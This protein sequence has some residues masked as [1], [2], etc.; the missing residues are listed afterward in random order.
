M[1][2]DSDKENQPATQQQQRN[3]ITQPSKPNTLDG[4]R[5]R[6]ATADDEQQ[7]QHNIS[8]TKK[9]KPSHNSTNADNT[10]TIPS[11]LSPAP[12]PSYASFD[13][14]LSEKDAAYTQLLDKYNEL[15]KQKLDSMSSLIAQYE[16][17]TTQLRSSSQQLTKHW[18]DKYD[19]LTK[20]QH[21]ETALRKKEAEAAMAVKDLALAEKDK[22]LKE[23]ET[24]TTELHTSLAAANEQISNYLLLTGTS[25]T[26]PA[27]TSS[28]SSS[29]SS[30]STQRIACCMVN[31]SNRQ[32]RIDFVL[33]TSA[34]VEEGRVEY[35][36]KRIEL[37]G[38]AYPKCL[39]GSM[40]FAVDRTPN[41]MRYLLDVMYKKVEDD[42]EEVQEEKAE[43]TEQAA[44][45]EHTPQQQ[46]ESHLEE[47]EQAESKQATEMG[48]GAGNRRG[49]NGVRQRR[50]GGRRSRLTVFRKVNVCLYYIL[51]S[52]LNAVTRESRTEDSV[53]VAGEEDDID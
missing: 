10:S 16:L 53:G 36:P 7:Q 21:K 41:F 46:L 44:S 30:S 39:K 49:D 31:A 9:S 5:N 2:D 32:R 37:G 14:L 45:S 24:S 4:K 18:Q 17:Q 26:A 35:R 11:P 6:A 52:L 8:N 29:S 33:D 34:S 47:S 19:Q 1:H 38:V 3:T 42:D 50:R 25:I 27:A 22:Q 51:C 12:T 28:S 23:K 48:R 40:S 15:K 43:Q 20:Q 13:A